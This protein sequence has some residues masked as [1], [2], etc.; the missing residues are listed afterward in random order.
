MVEQIVSHRANLGGK[1]RNVIGRRCKW[2]LVVIRSQ[3]TPGYRYQTVGRS[4]FLFR[5]SLIFTI[6][7][8]TFCRIDRRERLSIPSHHILY[9]NKDS[10]STETTV[11][12]EES[13]STP[14]RAVHLRRGPSS[15]SFQRQESRPFTLQ[16]ECW[17]GAS[18]EEYLIGMLWFVAI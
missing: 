10:R 18:S 15:I 7:I 16:H 8:R 14:L 5:I 1:A 4:H 13:K 6:W 11:L 17:H 3:I 2:V 12:E 9:I